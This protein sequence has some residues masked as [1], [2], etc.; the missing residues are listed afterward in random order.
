MTFDRRDKIR[1]QAARCEPLASG[2]EAILLDILL[3]T[4]AS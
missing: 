4:F 2:M 1:D 3:D